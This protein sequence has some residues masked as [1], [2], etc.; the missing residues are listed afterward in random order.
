MQFSQ[1]QSAQ[2]GVCFSQVDSAEVAARFV[3]AQRRTWS[4]DL[5]HLA[6]LR[7]GTDR[8]A[9]AGEH[10]SARAHSRVGAG[11]GTHCLVGVV[12]EGGLCGQ[13]EVV[14]PGAIQR[15]SKTLYV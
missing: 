3:L 7:L 1:A 8:A 11:R 15:H 2:A 4:Q 6:L 9:G 14:G 5:P 12:L 13:A 10:W